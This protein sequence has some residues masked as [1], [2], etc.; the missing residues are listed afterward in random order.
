VEAA[1]VQLV[2]QAQQAVQQDQEVRQ[3][4]LVFKVLLAHKVLRALVQ[5][6][7]PVLEQQDPL[8]A[9]AQL[10]QLESRVLQVQLV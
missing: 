5:L 3:V 8:V 1:L 7:Q 4:Q 6:V 2:Q 9:R 10:G